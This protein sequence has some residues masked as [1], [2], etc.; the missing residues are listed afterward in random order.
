MNIIYR[1][2]DIHTV[3]IGLKYKAEI[4][5]EFK[6]FYDSLNNKVSLEEFSIKE[7]GA[8]VVVENEQELYNLLMTNS[9]GD[10]IS[11]LKI[12][13][14]EEW[15][16]EDDKIYIMKFITADDRLVEVIV[17]NSMLISTIANI[18]QIIEH[19]IKIIKRY[20]GKKQIIGF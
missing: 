12:K 2:N 5:N 15:I 19:N 4:Y 6:S 3:N 20:D 10:E 8:M 1:Y 18:R 14:V 17:L 9:V 7:F 13:E 11:Q 16:L